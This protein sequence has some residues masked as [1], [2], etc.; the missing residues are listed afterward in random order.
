MAISLL[1]SHQRYTSTK[2]HILACISF[3]PQLQPTKHENRET[4][5]KLT[6]RVLNK[7]LQ[8]QYEQQKTVSDVS[9]TKM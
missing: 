1:I 3:Y 7:G 2:S 5:K 8:P 4:Q 6:T 9:K